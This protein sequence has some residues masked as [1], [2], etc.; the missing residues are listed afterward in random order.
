MQEMKDSGC[1]FD[2]VDS[3]TKY[4]YKDTVVTCSSFVKI[5]VRKSAI[6][7]IENDDKYCFLWSILAKLHLR[8]NSHPNRV[9]NYRQDFNFQFW[10]LK[11]SLV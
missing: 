3:V 2:Q 1:R 8:Y 9:S 6:L 7:I 10:F 11:W 4:F 5:P